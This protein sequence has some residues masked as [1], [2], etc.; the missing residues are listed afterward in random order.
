MT[1]IPLFPGSRFIRR[2]SPFG[3]GIAFSLISDGKVRAEIILDEHK[4]GAPGMAHGGATAAILDEA[5]GAA[6]YYAGRPGMTIT[7]TVNYLQPV[8]LNTLLLLEAWVERID[9][10]KTYTAALLRLPDS[11][12]AVRATA[13]FITNDSLVNWLKTLPWESET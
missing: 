10:K 8:P 12:V 9:G 5:M 11:A 2:E 7:M 13:I 1:D 4:Q 3:F 6:A